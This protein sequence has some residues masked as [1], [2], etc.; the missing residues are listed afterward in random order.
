LNLLDVAAP[1]ELLR[2][3]GPWQQVAVPYERESGGPDHILGVQHLVECVLSGRRPILSVEH[4]AHVVS[5]ITAAERSSWEC[6]AVE[7]DP[8]IWQGIEDYDG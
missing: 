7:V 3:G 1:V 4:A 8:T 5:V 2:N 6:R